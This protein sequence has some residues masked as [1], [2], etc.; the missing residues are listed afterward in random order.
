MSK[1]LRKSFLVTTAAA[2]LVTGLTIASAQTGGGGVKG[3]AGDHGMSQ[4]QAGGGGGGGA[5]RHQGPSSGG[6]AGHAQ[7]QPGSLGTQG[8]TQRSETGQ[9][10]RA[11]GEERKALGEQK[12][13]K[14]LGEQKGTKQLGEQ[15]GTK[16][17]GEQ[18]GTKQLGE[19]K[20]NKGT[21]GQTTTQRRAGQTGFAQGGAQ[22]LHRGGRD[23][24]RGPGHV[25][26]RGGHARITETTTLSSPASLAG[27]FYTRDVVCS[28]GRGSGSPRPL[29]SRVGSRRGPGFECVKIGTRSLR[30]RQIAAHIT[31]QRMIARSAPSPSSP[32]PSARR[33]AALGPDCSARPSK[34]GDHAAYGHR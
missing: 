1:T 12:G 7:T 4:G 5:E 16:Q 31:A 23:R 22:V 26:N 21:S 3:G 13:T 6:G 15:K 27:L 10:G 25:R 19:Q 32:A 2:A 24:V 20:G 11:M 17:L 8:H 34:P 29:G 28:H 14:Q 9:T 30:Q 18:K 33:F